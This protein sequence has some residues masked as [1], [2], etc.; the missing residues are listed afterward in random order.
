MSHEETGTATKLTHE[1]LGEQIVAAA[2][3]VHNVLGPGL[4]E[5]VYEKALCHELTLRGLSFQN[6]IALP[7]LYKG[8]DLECGFRVDILAEDAVIIEVKSI[9]NILPPHEAQLLTHMKFAKKHVGFIFNFNV[10]VFKHGIVRR[11]L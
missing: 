8:V 5:A 11:V 4:L 6:Q 9:A 3:E 10:P 1:K 7:V 2:I